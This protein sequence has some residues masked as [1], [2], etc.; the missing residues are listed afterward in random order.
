MIMFNQ[1]I[2]IWAGAEAPAFVA[3]SF[4]YFDRLGVKVEFRGQDYESDCVHLLFQ[5]EEFVS[6]ELLGSIFDE[7]KDLIDI[8]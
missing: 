1:F 6:E 4:E 3:K 2:M 7:Y 8:R 5:S